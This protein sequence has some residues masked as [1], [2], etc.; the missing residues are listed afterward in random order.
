MEGPTLPSEFLCL[1]FI[2]AFPDKPPC[3][4]HAGHSTGQC[5]F[6]GSLRLT[7][8]LIDY[9][10]ELS[11]LSWD[12][13]ISCQSDAFVNQTEAFALKSLTQAFK[14]LRFTENFF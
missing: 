7:G 1:V 14:T 2:A 8:P 4:A 13:S 6:L 5:F 3:P 11:E 12:T 10:K 9:T